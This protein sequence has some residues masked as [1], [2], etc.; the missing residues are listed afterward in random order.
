[1]PAYASCESHAFLTKSCRC[2]TPCCTRANSNGGTAGL[3]RSLFSPALA[4]F[5]TP[6][7]GYVGKAMSDFN[8]AVDSV[9]NAAKN[10]RDSVAADVHD[11]KAEAER[12]KRAERGETMSAGEKMESMATEVGEKAKA[13]FD[14]AKTDVRKP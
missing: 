8:K 4:T 9:A 5:V 12:Q 11:V 1:M 3:S 2:A 6:S 10:A 14:R 13:G 7:G